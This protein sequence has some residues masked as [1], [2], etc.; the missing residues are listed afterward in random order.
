MATWATP[1][2]E[3]RRAERAARVAFFA[4]IVSRA[5]A[6]QAALPRLAEVQQNC[7]HGIVSPHR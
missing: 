6:C 4:S 3:Q 2:F 5:Q 7:R 1:T